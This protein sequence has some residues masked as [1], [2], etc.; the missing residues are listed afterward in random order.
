M[1]YSLIKKI[2]MEIIDVKNE[3][4]TVFN[5]LVCI[6]KVYLFNDGVSVTLDE[7]NAVVDM[8][9][10]PSLCNDRKSAIEAIVGKVIY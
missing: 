5:E 8:D 7:L 3:F 1:C 2:V 10:I 4:K 9:G 6:G